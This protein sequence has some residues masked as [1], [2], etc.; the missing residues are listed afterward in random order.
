[1]IRPTLN[2]ALLSI[3]TSRMLQRACTN[4]TC[5]L[6][7]CCVLGVKGSVSNCLS[8]RQQIALEKL[9]LAGAD[10]GK[11]SLS[12]TIRQGLLQWADCQGGFIIMPKPCRAS[13]ITAEQYV[14]ACR[15]ASE[16][17]STGPPLCKSKCAGATFMSFQQLR[18]LSELIP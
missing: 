16:K 12:P 8:K 1:M 7:F 2:C 11:Y 15:P 9:P 13:K 5:L 4:S 10:T 14:S 17:K 6:P 3:S 18:R